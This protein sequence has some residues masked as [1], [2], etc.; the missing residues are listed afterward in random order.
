MK[1]LRHVAIIMDGNRRW[2][3]ENGLPKI[4]GH[5]RGAKNLRRIAE[6][7]AKKGISFLTLFTL[8]TENI[9]NR[10]EGEV[11]HLYALLEK[12]ADERTLFQENDVRFG[13]I[14]DLGGLPEK[15]RNVLSGL[16]DSTS[17]NSGMTLTIA[18]NY[19]GR[20]E[21][22]RAISRLMADAP[23]VPVTEALFSEYLDTAGMPDVDLL[24]RTAGH[25]R[26]SNFLPWQSTYAELYFTD[27]KWPAFSEDDFVRAIEWFGEQQRNRGK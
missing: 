9:K 4:A 16:K 14:G 13:V 11:T 25:Q 1:E 20:D 22:V 23:K 26:I 18:V 10:S 17:G 24:I 7:A 21:I 5:T 27:V 12:I 19:G 6:S 8:S 3:V 15:T 2:A